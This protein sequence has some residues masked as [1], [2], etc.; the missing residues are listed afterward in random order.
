VGDEV[1]ERRRCGRDGR[2][3]EV[4]GRF[5]R[6]LILTVQDPRVRDGCSG[7]V[8]GQDSHRAILH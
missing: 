2:H 7:S 5:R 8:L 6:H 4:V 1:V 3:R